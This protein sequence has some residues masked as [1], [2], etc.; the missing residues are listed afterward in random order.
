MAFTDGSVNDSDLAAKVEKVIAML[1]QRQYDPTQSSSTRFS[2]LTATAKIRSGVIDNRDL[3]LKASK[4]QIR[5]LGTV[6]L[7]SDMVDY[8][9]RLMKPGAVDERTYAPIDVTG[10]LSGVSYRFN[11]KEYLKQLADR[12][13]EKV[14]KKAKERIDKEINKALEGLF[15]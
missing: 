7:V 14:E 10:P 9:L 15:K 3:H 5:G 8:Q 13:K 11:E 4:F 2:S 1:E 6:N 12:Q